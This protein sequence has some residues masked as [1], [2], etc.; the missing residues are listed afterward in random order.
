LNTPNTIGHSDGLSLD[1]VVEHDLLF[2][3]SEF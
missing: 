2:S 1:K 3:R